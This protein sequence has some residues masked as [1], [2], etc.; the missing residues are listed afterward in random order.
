M[1]RVTQR[2]ESDP[3]VWA[4]KTT[5][6]PRKGGRPD[7]NLVPSSSLRTACAPSRAHNT[8]LSRPPGMR[9]P[10]DFG[11]NPLGFTVTKSLAAKEIANGRLAMIATAGFILQ[12]VTTHESA[13][14][15]L[16]G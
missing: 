6:P 5:A 2:P 1:G 13:L 4:R 11:F 8:V 16:F 9:A 3:A 10:G 7:S 14:K 12:G 15:N